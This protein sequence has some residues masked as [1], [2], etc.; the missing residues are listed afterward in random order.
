M[1]NLIKKGLW[2]LFITMFLV[3]LIVVMLLFKGTPVEQS[4]SGATAG[5]EYQSLTT[6]ATTSP[7]YLIY[8]G[9]G[10][11]G[12]IVISTLGTGNVIFYDATSTT[13]WKRTIQATTSLPVIATIGASQAAGTYVYDT[14]FNGG[15]MAVYNGAQGTST[16]MFRK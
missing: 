10:T 3:A 12:S 1:E 13:Y 14:T 9:A 8:K 5:N 16:V 7:S 6:M 11:F 15:L 2:Y 4:L